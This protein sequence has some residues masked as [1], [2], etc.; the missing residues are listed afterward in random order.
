MSSTISLSR[1]RGS[2][3]KQRGVLPVEF[4][5]SPP[6]SPL[7]TDNAHETDEE[8]QSSHQTYDPLWDLVLQQPGTHLESKDE[9]LWGPTPISELKNF[10]NRYSHPECPLLPP[11][12]P[13]LSQFISSHLLAPLLAHAK[14]VSTSLVRLYLDDLNFV[15]HLDVL[16]SFW[17]GGD[18][19][20]LERVNGAL[21]G[22][23]VAGAGEALGQGRRAR[24][25][26]RLGLVA[27]AEANVG[28]LKLDAAAGE[29][30]DQR[31]W[32]IGL[33]LGLSERSKWPPGGSELAYALRTTLLEEASRYGD[34]GEV[35]EGI[36]DRV[37]FA[38]R[39][40]PEDAGDGRRARWLDPQGE[41]RLCSCRF[42][43]KIQ[44]SSEY[45]VDCR[46]CGTFANT[47]KTDQQSARL[48]VPFLFPSKCHNPSPPASVDGEI[49]DHPELFA[50]TRAGRDGSPI[51]VL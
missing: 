7:V 51:N 38:L 3:R 39:D 9:A 1:L 13:I 45:L 24:T 40:L 2:H 35:W 17:L 22:K 34:K 37:S 41:C 20:F 5:A 32:G 43:L 4:T 16:R 8:D 28:A 14:L 50:S 33:G 21:F 42:Q 49:P 27:D 19:S 23:D 46:R 44:Q 30:P 12:T 15:D 6:G 36:E 48:P 31:E 25:R 29:G 18:V 11:S 47:T 10:I 26:A